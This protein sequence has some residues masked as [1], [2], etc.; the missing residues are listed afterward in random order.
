VAFSCQG[1][2]EDYFTTNVLTADNGL[3]SLSNMTGAVL[4][5]S[6]GKEAYAEEG[7]NR[8]KFTY[9]GLPGYA[10]ERFPPDSNN[11]VIFHLR[12]KRLDEK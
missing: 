8:S 1:Y 4:F 7:T 12:K 5:V 10:K 6:V 3:F 9:T 2:P 11:P